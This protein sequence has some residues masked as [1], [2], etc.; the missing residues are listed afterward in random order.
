MRS[1]SDGRPPPR[2]GHDDR[3]EVERGA[4]GTGERDVSSI[5][6]GQSTTSSA[7]KEGGSAGAMAHGGGGSGQ[8]RVELFGDGDRGYAWIRCRLEEQIV[9]SELPSR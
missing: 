4:G 6:R 2:K 3:R 7:E 9:L 8:A 1:K 5:T